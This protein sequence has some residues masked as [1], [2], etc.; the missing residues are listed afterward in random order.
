MYVQ[1]VTDL[2]S[3]FFGGI[4][5]LGGIPQIST[6]IKHWSIAAMVCKIWLGSEPDPGQSSDP[7]TGFTPNL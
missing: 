2:A 3:S 5:S 1:I 7:G 6:W 4:R